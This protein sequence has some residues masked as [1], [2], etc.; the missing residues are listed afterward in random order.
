VLA[1]TWSK[2]STDFDA[3]PRK[4]NNDKHKNSKE[5]RENKEEPKKR[6]ENDP[7][8]GAYNGYDPKYYISSEV[9]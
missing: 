9:K 2:K 1:T 5:K 3:S 7:N 8:D 4:K 6:K